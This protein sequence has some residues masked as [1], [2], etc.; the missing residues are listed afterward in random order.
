MMLLLATLVV[1]LCMA[2]T[3][4]LEFYHV[5]DNASE[6][7]KQRASAFESADLRE[8][9]PGQH[10][11]EHHTTL[12]EEE[13]G[14]DVDTNDRIEEVLRDAP[15]WNRLTSQMLH[16]LVPASPFVT[17]I[18]KA[19]NIDPTKGGLRISVKKQ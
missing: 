8:N 9:E 6:D 10:V 14:P 3:I 11:G 4:K 16:G 7:V 2:A 13:F 19:F 15:S 1:G 18:A 5:D 12:A 17:V